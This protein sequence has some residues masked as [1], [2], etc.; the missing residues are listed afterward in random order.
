M[1]K[2]IVL[3]AVAALVSITAANAQGGFQ[4]RTVEERVKSIHEKMDSAFHLEPAKLVQVDSIFANSYRASDAA[5][6]EM[7]ASGNPDRDAMRAKMTE[8]STARNEKLKAVLTADQMKTWTDTI[9]PSMR[10]QRGNRPPGQ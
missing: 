7:M 8:L 2:Q 6:E 4:R 9:E 10:P 1:K 3:M 5:R